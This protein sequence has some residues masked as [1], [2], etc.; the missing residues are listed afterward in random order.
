[1]CTEKDKVNF[2]GAL[3]KENYVKIMYDI[4][5]IEKTEFNERKKIDTKNLKVLNSI[6][7]LELSTN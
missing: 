5:L 3:I 6:Y 2:R 1:M 7:M 4:F